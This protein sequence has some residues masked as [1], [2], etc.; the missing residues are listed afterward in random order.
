MRA[1]RSAS[2]ARRR[3]RGPRPMIS[4]TRSPARPLHAGFMAARRSRFR[5]TMAVTISTCRWRSGP[6]AKAI[7][8]PPFRCIMAESLFRY[9]RVRNADRISGVFDPK[10]RAP[11]ARTL[12]EGEKIMKRFL[13][14]AAAGAALLAGATAASAQTYYDGGYYYG[15][16]GPFVESGVGLQVGPV[17]IGVYGEPSYPAY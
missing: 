12:G 2:S 9:R 10:V 7:G 11:Y 3:L 5:A 8:N 15:A 1:C 16:P 13:L 4:S 6:E 17:G 14:C